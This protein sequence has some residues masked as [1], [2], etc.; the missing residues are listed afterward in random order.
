MRRS[1]VL[2]LL[3]SNNSSKVTHP[4]LT[5]N[6]TIEFSD[7]V[8]KFSDGSDASVFLSTTTE[9]FELVEQVL[10]SSEVRFALHRSSVGNMLISE[11]GSEQ[12]TKRESNSGMIKVGEFTLDN[13]SA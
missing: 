12:F 10:P 2:E 3:M 11:V 6:D 9:D 1:E 4:N 7:G 5:N 8:F 13:L